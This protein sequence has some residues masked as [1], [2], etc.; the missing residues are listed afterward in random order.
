M[1]S[2]H[3]HKNRAPQRCS[4]IS[5]R[6]LDLAS[7]YAYLEERYHVDFKSQLDTAFMQRFEHAHVLW[8]CCAYVHEWCTAHA[9]P[10]DHGVE[11]AKTVAN[12]AIACL[13]EFSLS[14]RET[15]L[16]LLAC[17]LHDVDDH[18][19]TH[20]REL[21]AAQRF[22]AMCALTG[23]ERSLVLDMVRNVSCSANG[24]RVEAARPRW[25]YVPRD[26]DRLEALGCVG[27]YRA[28]IYSA[29]R[30]VR[31][32]TP[33]TPV[34]A[35]PGEVMRHATRERYEAYARGATSASLIDHYYDKV[36]HIHELSSGSRTLAEIASA[37]HDED[38]AFTYT[39]TRR[40]MALLAC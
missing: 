6:P 2:V 8:Q 29:E 9:F 40:V 26:A 12:H 34:L 11:H 28:I 33:D 16:V 15:L 25:F 22:L 31:T 17:L 1:T 19:F 21:V 38:I 7:E 39:Y 32:H 10:E 13:H 27:I 24:N 35:A 14:P 20:L 37:R 4:D 3:E 36:L 5:S 23:A 18:K 30:G